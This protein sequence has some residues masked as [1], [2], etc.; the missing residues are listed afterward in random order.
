VSKIRRSPIIVSPTSSKITEVREKTKRQLAML[1]DRIN[2]YDPT[3]GFVLHTVIVAL[4]AN[5]ISELSSHCDMFLVQQMQ[6]KSRT[7]IPK[8]SVN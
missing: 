7:G 3:I 5:K 1:A 6:Q 8:E 2:V 4:E